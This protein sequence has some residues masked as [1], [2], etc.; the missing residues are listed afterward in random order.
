MC[1][2][3]LSSSGVL[4][5]YLHLGSAGFL[6]GQDWIVNILCFVRH[7]VSVAAATILLCSSSMK[8]VL[9]NMKMNERGCV[10]T[11]Q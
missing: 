2:V 4:N 10:P 6:F 7:M 11:R 9:G 1:C 5:F 8:A 3:Q